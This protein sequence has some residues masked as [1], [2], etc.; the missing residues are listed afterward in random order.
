MGG[1]L[2]ESFLEQSSAPRNSTLRVL[3]V[4]E[5]RSYREALA[6][7]LQALCPAATVTY[8]G[9]E[10]LCRQME[11][12]APHL[13]ISSRLTPDAKIAVRV[14]VELYPD[15]GS[16]SRVGVDGQHSSVDG[17]DLDGLLALLEQTE[18]LIRVG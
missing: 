5:P 7:T 16:L 14:W 2:T 13:I 11:S 9:P 18:T 1:A 17:M 3:L 4:N 15:H 8:A 10:T 6:T 12:F